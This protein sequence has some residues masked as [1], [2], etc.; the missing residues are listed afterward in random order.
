MLKSLRAAAPVAAI[1]LTLLAPGAPASADAAKAPAPRQCFWTHQVSGFNAPNDRTVNL[2][3]GVRDVYR[4]DLFAPCHDVNWNEQIALES[5]GQ[6]D[7]CSGLD[8][9]IITQTTA[10]PQRCAVKTVRKLTPEEVAALPAKE[11]P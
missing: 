2:R 7:I 11:R 9:T 5:R 6:P 8:A 1:I 4:L 3:V 10:G